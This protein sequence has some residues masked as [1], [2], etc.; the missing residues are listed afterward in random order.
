DLLA[1]GVVD[2]LELEARGAADRLLDLAEALGVAARHLDD[3][4]LV[5]GRDRRLAE[6]ELVDAARDGV[7]GLGDGAIADL[8]LDVRADLEGDL[9]VAGSLRLG[10]LA[11]EL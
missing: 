11:E 9:V 2:H 4:V 10:Q 1:V 8:R 6:A 5:A 3:D 7:L